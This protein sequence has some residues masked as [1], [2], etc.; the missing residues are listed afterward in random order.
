[1]SLE[2]A[3]HEQLLLEKASGVSGS[4]ATHRSSSEALSGGP[5]SKRIPASGLPRRRLHLG[6]ARNAHD[7]AVAG[8]PWRRW[9]RRKGRRGWQVLS[10]LAAGLHFLLVEA[11]ACRAAAGARPRAR[12]RRAPPAPPGPSARSPAEPRR[13]WKK[14]REPSP[15]C[16]PCRHAT[17]TSPPPA[18]AGGSAR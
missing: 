5:R 11:T 1:M 7:D 17:I 10:F 13:A 12:S 14:Q 15:C 9:R 16:A 3:P 18:P 4:F 6:K 8:R 2:D